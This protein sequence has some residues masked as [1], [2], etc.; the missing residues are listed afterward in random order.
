MGQIPTKILVAQV[1][2]GGSHTPVCEQLHQAD[3]HGGAGWGALARNGP[4]LR[5]ASYR[6]GKSLTSITAFFIFTFETMG[7]AAVDRPLS[8]QSG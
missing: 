6:H 5:G 7:R 2:A 4:S 8:A 1:A 3:G